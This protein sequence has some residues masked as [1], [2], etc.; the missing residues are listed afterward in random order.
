MGAIG[1]VS[2]IIYQWH[3]AISYG[4]AKIVSY[5]GGVEF[6]LYYLRG[7]YEKTKTDW[8][9]THDALVA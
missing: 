5:F 4:R 9:H 7:E 6:K 8:H 1:V 2:S 3:F